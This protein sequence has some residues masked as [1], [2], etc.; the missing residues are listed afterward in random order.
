MT[1]QTNNLRQT[2]TGPMVCLAN[3]F[4][5][6]GN[7]IKLLSAAA[8]QAKR[9]RDRIRYCRAPAG[10]REYAEWLWENTPGRFAGCSHDDEIAQQLKE[11]F[12]ALKIKV[13]AVL[14]G[15]F[16]ED[17][18]HDCFDEATGRPCCNSP[19]HTV[20]KLTE[21]MMELCDLVCDRE[22]LTTAHRTSNQ[23]SGRAEE[24]RL[25]IIDRLIGRLDLIDRLDGY[26]D[27]GSRTSGTCLKRKD[28]QDVEDCG[29]LQA[30]GIR[31]PLPRLPG[32]LPSNVLPAECGGA[33]Q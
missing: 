2:N 21:V 31:P 11:R 13:F 18:E 28:R 1:G 5:Q 32:P 29:V 12:A 25:S 7:R 15:C 26:I 6:S 9:V 22:A 4:Q 27:G 20:L 19:E 17:L 30:L 23:T 24:D 10:C 8:K 3:G 14:T 16:W 33:R